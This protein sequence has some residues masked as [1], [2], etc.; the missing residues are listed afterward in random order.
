MP[1]LSGVHT[2]VTTPGTFL[3]TL[4]G[5]QRVSEFEADAVLR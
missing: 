3:K 4:E 2:A 5:F 1:L